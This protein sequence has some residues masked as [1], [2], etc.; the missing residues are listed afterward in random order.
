M[1]SS[2][3]YRIKTYDKLYIVELYN[4][5]FS[6]STPDLATRSKAPFIG[7]LDLLIHQSIFRCIKHMLV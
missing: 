7:A 1:W 3:R 4:P 6:G 2:C 5:E